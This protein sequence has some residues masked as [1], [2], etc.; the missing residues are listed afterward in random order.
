MKLWNKFYELLWL[1]ERKYKNFIAIF[2]EHCPLN[3]FIYNYKNNMAITM[4]YT[5]NP[6]RFIILIGLSLFKLIFT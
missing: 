3:G 5:F 2:K 1:T 6:Q 4:A